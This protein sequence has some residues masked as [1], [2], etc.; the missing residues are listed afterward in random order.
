MKIPCSVVLGR[1]ATV[2]LRQKCSDSPQI[3]LAVCAEA[4][5]SIREV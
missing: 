5:K 3:L 1:G 2:L 4:K